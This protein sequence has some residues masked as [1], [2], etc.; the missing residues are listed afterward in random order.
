M[1]LSPS[2][3][4]EEETEAQRGRL[5][6]DSGS[7]SELERG[8]TRAQGSRSLGQSCA[9]FSAPLFRPVS[10]LAKHVHREAG[11]LWGVC[12]H[13]EEGP[14]LKQGRRTGH[15][16]GPDHIPGVGPSFH[17]R[18]KG[19]RMVEKARLVLLQL[20]TPCS[21]AVRETEAESFRAR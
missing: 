9:C 17:L 16:S 7:H 4:T 15:G 5:V 12:G 14:G 18:M 10:A 2:C 11:A 3:A 21:F 20:R 13:Q 1:H 8:A 19:W 6:G